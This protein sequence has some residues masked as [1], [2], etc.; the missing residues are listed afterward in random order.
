MKLLSVITLAVLLFTACGGAS[1]GPKLEVNDGSKTSTLNI[2]TGEVYYGNVISTYPGKPSLQTFAHD[3]VLANYD[4]DQTTMHKPL[5]A[6]EQMRVE[7]QLTGEAGTKEDSPLKVGTYRVKN[8]AINRVRSIGIRTF[9]GGKENKLYFETM[10]SSSTAA[11]DV[12]IK[13]ITGDTV[14]GEMNLTDGSK[15]IKGTFVAKLPAA[16]K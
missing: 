13:S 6:P 1:S 8:E 4:I 10:S 16:K 2:K 5:T 12:T 3:I 14:S 9:A 11:G 7:I 15:S